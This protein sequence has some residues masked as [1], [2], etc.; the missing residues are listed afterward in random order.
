MSFPSSFESV[1]QPVS[2]CLKILDQENKPFQVTL[3]L[4]IFKSPYQREAQPR[5]LNRQVSQFQSSGRGI[6]THEGLLTTFVVCHNSMS[7][8]PSPFFSSASPSQSI[9]KQALQSDSYQDGNRARPALLDK[10][11]W[12]LTA[13]LLIFHLAELTITPF[14]T[15]S[16]SCFQMS[17]K[18][19][20][21]NMLKW[22]SSLS[23]V[24]LHSFCIF[25]KPF[26]VQILFL[27]LSEVTLHVQ[28]VI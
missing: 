8:L 18:D 19:W 16:T 5:Y 6:N 21:K 26:H 11:L 3:M 13:W 1:A 7:T 4:Q 27:K 28:P 20:G 25:F 17:T 12:L 22:T 10:M 24:P 14:L 2:H 23:S 9:D 15:C